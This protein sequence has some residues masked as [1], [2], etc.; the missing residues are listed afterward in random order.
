MAYLDRSRAL[1]EQLADPDL[2][3]AALNNLALARRAAGDLPGALDL[4]A[5]ALDLCAAIGDRHREAALHNNLADVLHAMGRGEE[6]MTHLKAAV[7]IFGE[8]GVEEEPRP[9]IW[10]LVRW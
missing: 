1:G 10:K 2:R 7:E 3:V 5:E 8:V 9:E 6:A 4:T